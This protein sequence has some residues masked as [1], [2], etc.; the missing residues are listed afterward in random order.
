MLA[1]RNAD[2]AEYVGCYGQE[3]EEEGCPSGRTY[4][5]GFRDARRRLETPLALYENVRDVMFQ[6]QDKNKVK[7]PPEIDTV[8]SDMI[9]QGCAFAYLLVDTAKYLL[10]QR[11]TRVYAVA[12]E[13]EQRPDVL[14]SQF[15]EVMTLFQ[16]DARWVC[17][18]YIHM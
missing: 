4:Q 3:G 8:E 12:S 10:P 17:S 2:R 6:R 5:C 15:E 9:A 13:N 18:N 11:R 1:L 16:S 7:H 14:Q